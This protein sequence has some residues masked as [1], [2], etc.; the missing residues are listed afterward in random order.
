MIL[1]LHD[2]DVDVFI[3]V[4]LMLYDTDIDEWY[5][6]NKTIDRWL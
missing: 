4:M 1:M 5:H 2:K 3:A 6:N